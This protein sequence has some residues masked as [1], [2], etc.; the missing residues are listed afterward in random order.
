M[1]PDVTTRYP[2]Q[3]PGLVLSTNS[4]G[5]GYV[6][7]DPVNWADHSG[8]FRHCS[9][10]SGC[11]PEGGSGGGGGGGDKLPT[12]EELDIDRSGGGNLCLTQY[13]PILPEDS[14]REFISAVTVG[15]GELEYILGGDVAEPDAASAS[16][17]QPSV[18]LPLFGMA[19]VSSS[20]LVVYWA[21][22]PQ[23]QYY[24]GVTVDYAA[25][26]ARHGSRFLAGSGAQL[27]VPRMNYAAAKG[28]QQTLI[29]AIRPKGLPLANVINS[30]S[31]S[32]PYY[33]RV[34]QMG[35]DIMK[36]AKSIEIPFWP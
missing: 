1:P 6:Q 23:G 13:D 34:K 2:A 15:E 22:T 29:E 33:D 18:P 26:M 12:F 28:L 10:G 14:W 8:L 35:S 19:A 11:R 36:C 30:I 24:I 17:L 21:R 20:R 31:P 32:N 9:D 3:F 25:R 4:K 16:A 5:T 27:D 7:G